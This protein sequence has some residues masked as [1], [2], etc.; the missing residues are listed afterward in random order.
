MNGGFFRCLG[1]SLFSLLLVAGVLVTGPADAARLQRGERVT[2]DFQNVDL[3]QVILFV[4][5]MTGKNYV[6]DSKLKGKVTVITPT[7]VTAL[8]AERIFESILSVQGF[9]VIERDGAYKIVPTKRSRAEGRDVI[10]ADGVSPQREETVVSRLI[11]VRHADPTALAASLKP[12]VHNWGALS[13]HVPGNAIIITDAAVTVN[14]VVTLIQAMDVPREQADWRLFPLRYASAARLEK[15]INSI[16]AE[17]NARKR[18][19]DPGVKIFSDAHSNALVAVAPEAELR[20]VQR[21]IE[22]MDRPQKSGSGNLHLYYPKNSKAEV[23]AKVLNELISKAASGG[24]GAGSGLKPLQLTRAVSVVGE[25]ETNTLI[26]AATPDDYQ[27]LLPII[28][29][30]DMR[31]LQVHVEA[32][33][34]EVTADRAADF[35]VEWRFTDVPSIGSTANK[36]FGGSTFTST[37]EAGINN[38]LALAGGGLAVGMMKGGISLGGN[39]IPN[40]GALL[41]ALQSDSDVNILATPNLVT[42][43]G[44]E[45]SIVVGENVPINTGSTISTAGTTTQNVERKN[46]GLTLKVTPR[47]IEEGWLELVVFQEQSSLAPSITIGQGETG[48]VT[49]TRSLQTTVNLKSGHTVVLGGLV[50]EEQSEQVRQVPCLGGV[51]GVGELFKKTG[52]SRNKSNLMVFIKPVIINTYADLLRVT[53]EKYQQSRHLWDEE[54]DQGSRVMPAMPLEKLPRELDF[55]AGTHRGRILM[56][57]LRLNHRFLRP[58]TTPLPR[59]G[60]RAKKGFNPVSGQR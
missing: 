30:L 47:V 44:V 20:E 33:I 1:L 4:A 10:L 49:K 19:N 24:K 52:R 55:P 38:P 6:V 5:D 28:E 45:S 40:L 17:Y 58:D 23:I 3:R 18:K 26:I 13:A 2:M 27:T 53:D 48:V 42:M 60:K 36:P 15:L 50:R 7:P 51:F 16:Y 8:E 22:K 54:A 31:R 34:I 32:L 21:L 29:G 39:T 46:V 12:L 14:K 11:R 37:D 43:D 35:G 41:R 56:P 25:K 59:R 9:T 57:S